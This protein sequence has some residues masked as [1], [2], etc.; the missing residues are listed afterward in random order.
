M[1]NNKTEEL[2]KTNLIEDIE[3]NDEL[4]NEKEMNE[5]LENCTKILNLNFTFRNKM[6]KFVF[7]R[8]PI[9]PED[10]IRI[11]NEILQENADNIK[12]KSI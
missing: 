4:N 3:N 8:L 6:D 7:D 2:P 9:T 10:K 5:M 12:N 11:L 1:D